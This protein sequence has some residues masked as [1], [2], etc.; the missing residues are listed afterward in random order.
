MLLLITTPAIHHIQVN[1]L[2]PEP[3]VSIIDTDVEAEVVASVETEDLI[4]E[5]EA[6]QEALKEQQR[7]NAERL[8]ELRAARERE[9]QEALELVKAAEAEEDACL[10]HPNLDLLFSAC[11]SE[12]RKQSHALKVCLS[13]PSFASLPTPAQA[14]KEQEAEQMRLA[15]LATLEKLRAHRE[16]RLPPEPPVDSDQPAVTVAFRLPEGARLS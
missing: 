13:L 16:A 10:Q 2:E 3:A 9:A 7:R 1:R 4:R 12:S 11:P 6:Q 8:A 14:R 15:K 5:W